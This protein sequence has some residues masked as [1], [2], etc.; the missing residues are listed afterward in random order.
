VFLRG[1]RIE[2]RYQN[3]ARSGKVVNRAMG[4]KER[5][6]R[7]SRMVKIVGTLRRKVTR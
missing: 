6:L 3:V 4:R 2:E 5:R 1:V 7:L